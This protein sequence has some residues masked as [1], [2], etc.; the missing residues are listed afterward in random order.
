[1]KDEC[2]LTGAGAKVNSVRV[3]AGK[4]YVKFVVALAKLV[5]AIS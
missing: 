5:S 3:P 4:E 1:M 2:N